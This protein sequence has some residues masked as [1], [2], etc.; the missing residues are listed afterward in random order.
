MQVT[1]STL[2][3]HNSAQVTFLAKE[4]C[5]RIRY[6]EKG[7]VHLSALENRLEFHN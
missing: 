7:F 4:K 1:Y 2:T 3:Q 5:T 6:E